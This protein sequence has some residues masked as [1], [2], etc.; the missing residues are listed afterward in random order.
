MIPVIHVYMCIFTDI[1]GGY[2]PSILDSMRCALH[3]SKAVWFKKEGD[4]QYIP[5]TLHEVLYMATVGGATGERIVVLYHMYI[6]MYNVMYC[7]LCSEK[8]VSG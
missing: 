5:L 6:T 8:Y 7:I 2:S 4:P 3:T 1:S